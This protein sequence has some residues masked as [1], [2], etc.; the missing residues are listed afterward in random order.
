M[1]F[2]GA[3]TS[4]LVPVFYLDVVLLSCVDHITCSFWLICLLLMLKVVKKV[5]GLLL[6]N[7]LIRLLSH[8][9]GHLISVVT[10]ILVIFMLNVFVAI[11]LVAFD[12]IKVI[13][14]LDLERD[15]VT[16]WYQLK[17]FRTIWKL[18]GDV[19]IKALIALHTAG[20]CERE[21]GAVQLYTE[22]QI[23]DLILKDYPEVHTAKLDVLMRLLEFP[24]EGEDEARPG[25]GATVHPSS[26]E[27]AED[28]G[29]A[30]ANNSHP[31]LDRRM[32]R[33]K[34]AENTRVSGK[35]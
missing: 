26:G 33:S 2:E 10:F 13:M 17:R 19:C 27:E 31:A 29:V 21:E 18:D 9:V 8:A 1:W 15:G 23:R 16:W 4:V 30:H 5:A 28:S 11:L 20:Q 35:V 32:T 3:D 14:A 12:E 7:L 6:P 24:H 22:G 25:W 34:I